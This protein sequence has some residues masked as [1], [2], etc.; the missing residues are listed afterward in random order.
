MFLKRF[1]HF[2][3]NILCPPTC[4]ICSE[5]VEE[6]H[7]LCPDCYSKLNFIT[8]PCCDICGKPFEYAVFDELTCG[9]CLKQKPHFSM[10][11]S[12]LSYD[13]F[14]KQLILAF[15]HA[16]HIELNKLFLKFIIQADKSIFQDIDTIIPVPLHWTRRL[17]RKYN[18]AGLL[19]NVLAKH[20]KISFLP[21]VLIR[22]KRT[23]SQGHKKRKDREKNIKNAFFVKNKSA[24]KGKNI[25]VVDDV[26]TTGSTLNECARI[27]K[28]NGAKDIKVLTV[29]RVSSL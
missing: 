27:L 18:Q 23:E 16:D 25:L 10:A 13:D 7:C 29:Y 6:A 19:A 9:A 5:K 21:T 12:V 17:K 4:P 22:T 15:K 28:K 14:S 3:L 2:F 1:G 11:R 20:L 24:I 8:K 26:M